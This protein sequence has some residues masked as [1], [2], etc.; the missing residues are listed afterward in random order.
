M[1]GGEE[2]TRQLK[3]FLASHAIITTHQQF[4]SDGTRTGWAFSIEYDESALEK[5]ETKTKV[6][7]R[8][9]L[10]PE[11]F[12]LFNKLRDWRKATSEKEEIPAYAVL[13][14]EQIADIARQRPKNLSQLVKTAGI[15]EARLKKYGAAIMEQLQP[16]ESTQSAS[17]NRLN[18]QDNKDETPE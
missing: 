13:N 18:S 14:N 15:G 8:E 4:V 3:P 2:A 9:A 10:R 11:D 1:Q 17:E 5:K 7:Y 6:D 16:V 12:V